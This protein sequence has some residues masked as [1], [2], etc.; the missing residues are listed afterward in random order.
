MRLG[1]LLTTSPEHQDTGTAL[2]VAR[3]ALD[4]GHHVE[5]KARGGA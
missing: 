2:Q 5:L 4:L 1:I 3:A